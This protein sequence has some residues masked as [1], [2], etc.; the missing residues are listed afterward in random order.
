MMDF[1]KNLSASESKYKY[2]GL[3][4]ET[5]SEF[6]TKDEIFK[7][8]FQGRIYKMKVNNKNCIMLTQLYAKYQF[9]E[10]DELRIILNKEG[11]FEFVVN[12]SKTPNT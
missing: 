4:K 6:P 10:D 7:V 9:K 3:P 12:V 11:I 2:V 1:V 8:K 5:R